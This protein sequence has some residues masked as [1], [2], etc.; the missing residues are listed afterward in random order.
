MLFCNETSHWKR[1]CKL[2]LEDLKKKKG[3]KTTSSGIYA[4]EVNLST[5]IS[6]VLDT[7]CGSH[8][9]VNV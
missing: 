9:C 8:I 6:Y 3:S 1:N 7:D 4:I 5:S 2:Y